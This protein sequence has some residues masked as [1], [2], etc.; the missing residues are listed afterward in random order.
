MNLLPLLPAPPES[1]QTSASNSLT[2]GLHRRFAHLLEAALRLFF[3]SKEQAASL[4]TPDVPLL[5]TT[6]SLS[7]TSVASAPTHV[8]LSPRKSAPKHLDQD[9]SPTTAPSLPPVLPAQRPLEAYAASSASPISLSDP[10][11][12]TSTPT[13]RT[14]PGLPGVS[15]WTAASPFSPSFLLTTTPGSHPDQDAFLTDTASQQTVPTS[16]FAPQPSQESRT[17]LSHILPDP[18][19]DD[20]TNPTPILSG[21]STETTGSHEP[22][23]SLPAANVPYNEPLTF[24][25]S[26]LPASSAAQTSAS[27][28]AFTS[29]PMASSPEG[30][31]P[32]P[33]ARSNLT[34][35]FPSRTPK[36]PAA[37]ALPVNGSNDASMTRTFTSPLI[38]SEQAAL[39]FCE[40]IPEQLQPSAS[41]TPDPTSDPTNEGRPLSPPLLQ[42]VRGLSNQTIHNAHPVTLSAASGQLDANTPAPMQPTTAPRTPAASFETRILSLPQRETAASEALAAVDPAAAKSA[43]TPAQAASISRVTPASE[44]SVFH[45]Q[46][47]KGKDVLDPMDTSSGPEKIA[48]S[49]ASPT[50]AAMLPAQ[51]ETL[52]RAIRAT[53]WF[54]MAMAFA[55]RIHQPFEGQM[56]E[57]ELVDEGIL[58]V[59]TRRHPDHVVVSVQLSD[60]QL[61][62]LVAAHA[63]RI[64]EALQAQYQTAVQF[65]LADGGEQGSRQQ[66]FDRTPT[67]GTPLALGS[68]VSGTAPGESSHARVLH[69]GS[70]HEWIG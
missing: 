1:A 34:P 70:H 64:Q 33:A 66:A 17:T 22:V 8:V 37:Q 30:Q 27:E 11:T 29:S 67:H 59:E 43:A 42:N 46:D 53:V 48:R 3:A 35:V 19:L 18:S 10:N 23:L 2:N 45:E 40:T 41:I 12:S 54:Q 60:P 16:Q 9:P 6:E 20:R 61:R 44:G 63:D 56:L 25:T 47:P 58:R 52:P 68:E 15:S 51:A 7:E 26:P 62:A 28:P 50:P 14:A 49:G 55:E 38:G 69:P 39:L 4:P 31:T 65:S 36:P 5:P 57:V 13:P 21:S 32:T 24:R